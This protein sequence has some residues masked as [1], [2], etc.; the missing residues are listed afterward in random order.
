LKSL[1]PGKIA[2]INHLVCLDEQ[3][4]LGVQQLG[5]IYLRHDY[6]F[7]CVSRPKWWWK[8]VLGATFNLLSA[9]CLNLQDQCQ[10]CAN[11]LKKLS[12]IYLYLLCD[13]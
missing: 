10:S 12:E 2:F 9:G 3:G 13:Q 1:Q 5:Q 4:A 8:K 6:I 11:G 7:I